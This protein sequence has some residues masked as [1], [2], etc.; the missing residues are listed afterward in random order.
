MITG[1][2]TFSEVLTSIPY[3]AERFRLFDCIGFERMTNLLLS[4][5]RAYQSLI[6][7]LVPGFREKRFSLIQKIVEKKKDEL[8]FDN[9]KLL[10]VGSSSDYTVKPSSLPE[11]VTVYAVDYEP[12][13]SQTSVKADACR[14]PF[15]DNSFDILV[16]SELVEHIISPAEVINEARRV[17]KKNG[18][19]VF[20]TP[21][22]RSLLLRPPNP[23]FL[24]PVLRKY[25]V[26]NGKSIFF[27]L[28]PDKLN[29]WLEE[30]KVGRFHISWKSPI[31]WKKLF[32]EY[33]RETKEIGIPV[34][35]LPHC[36]EYKNL[37]NFFIASHM[38]Y[39]LESP[40][41]SG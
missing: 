34:K 10:D 2:N 28:F 27:K 31:Y 41:S 13:Q 40:K 32:E 14:L 23:L 15:K 8:G 9:F 1:Y 22:L 20:T 18:T 19:A 21:W 16:A 12:P 36:R 38:M 3:N 33:F 35:P 37:H 25:F 39:I 4:F 5:K 29:Y 30:A 17:L 26:G 24:Q 6:S 7:Y 11:F